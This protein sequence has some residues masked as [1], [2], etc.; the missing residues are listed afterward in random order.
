VSRE[1]IRQTLKKAQLLRR[2]K[3][4]PRSSPRRP[5]AGLG[6]LPLPPLRGSSPATPPNPDGVLGHP[7]SI[8]TSILAAGWF[9]DGR[10]LNNYQASIVSCDWFAIVSTGSAYWNP[11][12]VEA[13]C[14]SIGSKKAGMGVRFTIWE[15]P[16]AAGSEQSHGSWGQ[17]RFCR[18]R[19]GKKTPCRIEVAPYWIQVAPCRR[20]RDWRG[21]KQSRMQNREADLHPRP[22]RGR[23]E[24]RKARSVIANRRFAMTDAPITHC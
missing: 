20:A 23:A 10:R 16:V 8:T 9:R 19:Y 5:Q 2:G 3:S 13:G 4:P 11:S 24:P 22:E 12:G 18:G 1:T 14:P 6:G 15:N 21:A 7:A 17:C